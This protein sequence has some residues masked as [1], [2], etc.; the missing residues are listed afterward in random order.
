MKFTNEFVEAIRR[1][2]NNM[3]FLLDVSELSE[4]EVNLKKQ[5]FTH[6]NELPIKKFSNLREFCVDS[7]SF[8][9]TLANGV[10]I[11]FVGALMLGRDGFQKKM[12]EYALAVVRSIHK[13]VGFINWLVQITKDC[14]CMSKEGEVI[15][16]DLGILGSLDPVAIDKASADLLIEASGKDIIRAA[17]SVDWSV[18]LKHGQEIGLGSM[19]YELINLT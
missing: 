15:A 13:G 14:D 7:S 10:D 11:F 17:N 4:I 2:K 12:A 18:Q 5:L 9:R 3:Q 16:D 6:W 8:A 1:K 19:D